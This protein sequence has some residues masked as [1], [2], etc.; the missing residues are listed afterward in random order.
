[1]KTF[2]LIHIFAPLRIVLRLTNSKRNKTLGIYISKQINKRTKPA[3]YYL[4]ICNRTIH[5]PP[6]R[7]PMDLQHAYSQYY[8][9]SSKYLYLLRQLQNLPRHRRFHRNRPTCFAKIG[10]ILVGRHRRCRRFSEVL[11]LPRLTMKRTRKK[12]RHRYLLHCQAKRYLLFHCTNKKHHRQF[13]SL[14]C[15]QVQPAQ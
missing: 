6:V 11:Q 14:A 3:H 10:A 12:T 2:I 7:I 5:P 1:M 4:S 15:P 13:A 9:P 8:A